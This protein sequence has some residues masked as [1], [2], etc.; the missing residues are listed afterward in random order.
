MTSGYWN[1]RPGSDEFVSGMAVAFTKG[2]S[3]LGLDY[4]FHILE[5]HP[6]AMWL[7]YDVQGSWCHVFSAWVLAQNQG[8]VLARQVWWGLLLWN[9]CVS[10]QE[11]GWYKVFIYNRDGGLKRLWTFSIDPDIQTHALGEGMPEGLPEVIASFWNLAARPL[12]RSIT[13]VTVCHMQMKVLGM[14]LGG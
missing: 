7:W 9:C 11:G 6:R 8:K 2:H 10:F 5:P 3:N 13:I 12:I 4:L 14:V 1:F